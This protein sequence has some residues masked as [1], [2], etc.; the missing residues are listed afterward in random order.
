[1]IIH[2]IGDEE[3]VTGFRLAGVINAYVVATAEE[4]LEHLRNIIPQENSGVVIITERLA[5]TVR[6]EIQTLMHKRVF[7][8]LVEIPDTWSALEDKTDS[9]AKAIRRAIGIELHLD[10]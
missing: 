1:M 6:R 8:I 3:T 5:E 7:P 2:I 9:L 4:L 10:G